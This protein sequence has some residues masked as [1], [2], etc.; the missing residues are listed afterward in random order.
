MAKWE[1]GMSRMAKRG[2]K[3]GGSSRIASCC[4][5]EPAVREGQIELLIIRDE[6]ETALVHTQIYKYLRIRMY[7]WLGGLVVVCLGGWGAMQES[8]L[9]K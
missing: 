2:T 8:Q 3:S 7:M 5:F 4:V 1:R 9:P 6:L